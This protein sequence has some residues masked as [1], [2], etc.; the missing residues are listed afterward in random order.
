M[1]KQLTFHLC[2]NREDAEEFCRKYHVKNATILPHSLDD[3]WRG[4]IVWYKD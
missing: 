1:K 4:F 2:D 3:G